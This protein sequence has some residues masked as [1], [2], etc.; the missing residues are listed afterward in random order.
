MRC[1]ICEPEGKRHRLYER[2]VPLNTGSNPQ[3]ERYYDEAGKL[4]VHDNEVRTVVYTCSNGHHFR[5]DAMSRCTHGP[6]G[7]NDQPMVVNGQKGMEGVYAEQQQRQPIR[8]GVPD[9]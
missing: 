7:W 8:K 2:R 6:C 4:H 3:V 5:L 1:P 9:A